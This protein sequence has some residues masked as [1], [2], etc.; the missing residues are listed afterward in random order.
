MV[1]VLAVDEVAVAVGVNLANLHTE[2]LVVEPSSAKFAWELTT[3]MEIS[4]SLFFYVCN[5][6][7]NSLLKTLNKKEN[8][9]IFLNLNRINRAIYTADSKFL[10][11]MDNIVRVLEHL[12]N[13]Q[14]I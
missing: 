6:N 10:V 9:N 8:I 14:I 11:G 2:A 7:I 1:P 5:N 4:S 13:I 3:S 12:R